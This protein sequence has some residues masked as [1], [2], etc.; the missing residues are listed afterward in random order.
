[1]RAP[2]PIGDVT[3]RSVEAGFEWLVP[4]E[5]AFGELAEAYLNYLREALNVVMQ[6]RANDILAWMKDNAPWQDQTGNARRTLFTQVIQGLTDVT[7]L[8]SHG[9]YYGFWLEVKWA[10]RY[11]IISPALDHWAPI[12]MQDL[13]KLVRGGQ[14]A[15]TA[16]SRTWNPDTQTASYEGTP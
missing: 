12:I 6:T 13:Q 4:P 1:M 14:F 2:E 5:Q 16:I 11:S 15:Q 3:L 7:I 8:L 9:M 10:G